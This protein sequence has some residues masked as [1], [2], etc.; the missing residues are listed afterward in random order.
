MTELAIAEKQASGVQNVDLGSSSTSEKDVP[1]YGSHEDHIFNDR[2]TA[3]YRREVYE[4][5]KYEGRHRFDPTYTW[6]AEEEKRLVRK[7]N[8]NACFRSSV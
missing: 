1:A 5:A 3:Q 8:N 7:V 6:T 2:V 4:S